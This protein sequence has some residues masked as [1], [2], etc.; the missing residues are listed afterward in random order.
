[1]NL[2]TLIIIRDV[3]TNRS[4]VEKVKSFSLI[5]IIN[6]FQCIL[7]ASSSSPFRVYP[8][9]RNHISPQNHIPFKHIV[10]HFPCILKNKR[11]MN[12]KHVIPTFFEDCNEQQQDRA[13]INYPPKVKWKQANIGMVTLKRESFPSSFSL[14]II[15]FISH[16]EFPKFTW[17]ASA[18]CL[19]G[20]L[21]HFI[22]TTSTTM[23]KTMNKIRTQ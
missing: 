22:S 10:K 16:L 15:G 11:N 17:T 12:N 9:T 8:A 7:T 6:A 3:C 14:I 23:K 4:T 13:V 1:M 5:P 20:D 18:S 2:L 19:Q 21:S